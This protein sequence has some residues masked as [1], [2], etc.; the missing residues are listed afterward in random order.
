VQSFAFVERLAHMSAL[1]DATVNLCDNSPVVR[2]SPANAGYCRA[3]TSKPDNE[4][5]TPDGLLVSRDLFFASKITGTAAEL[6]RRIAVE[7]N[8]LAAVAK[9]ADPACRCVILDLTLPGLSVSDFLTALPPSR[10]AVIAFGPHVQTARLEEAR[11]AGCDDVFP[12]SKFSAS[13]ASIL[14]QYLAPK[15]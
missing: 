6:G 12:R 2:F 10:A 8:V 13:L 7:G 1:W 11:D 5:R 14:T 9:A 4:P 3:M 15:S